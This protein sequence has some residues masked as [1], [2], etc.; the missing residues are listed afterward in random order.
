MG[1][2]GWVRF[3]VSG[4][5][6]LGGFSRELLELVSAKEDIHKGLVEMG[7]SDRSLLLVP[8]KGGFILIGREIARTLGLTSLVTSG[9]AELHGSR[10]LLLD[11][12]GSMM[13]DDPKVGGGR[14][15]IVS[16][17]LAMAPMPTLYTESRSPSE[18]QEIP[19]EEATTRP[20]EEEAR[21]ALEMETELLELTQSKD[22]LRMDLSR[23]AIKDYKKSSGFEMGL[24][25][26]G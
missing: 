8:P 21:G 3:S 25:R 19:A 7:V 22:A 12:S 9:V 18:V 4:A 2:P 5:S 26:M 11:L 6:T 17:T 13:C 14:L 1:A 23:Q 20:S 16:S 24:V 15:G 10:W